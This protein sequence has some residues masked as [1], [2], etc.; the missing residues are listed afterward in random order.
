MPDSM[1][2][3]LGAAGKCGRFF[4]YLLTWNVAR[5]KFDKRPVGSP[6]AVNMTYAQAHAETM[7]LRAIG[8]SATVG[9]WIM[10]DSGLFFL[11]IDALPDEY[12]LDE[13]AQQLLATFPGAFV[14]WST[15]KRGLHIV[16]RMTTPI[17]HSSRNDA[18]HLEFYTA[19]RGIALNIDAAPTGNMDSLHDVRA[20]VAQYFPPR[21][22]PANSGQRRPDWRGPNDDDA[23]IGRMLAARVSAAAAFGGKVSL[24]HLW[25]G[26]CTK[27]SGNDMALASHLAF[28]TGCDAERIERLMRRSGMVRDKWRTHRTYLQTTI[29]AA[30]AACTNVYKEPLPLPLL[31]VLEPNVRSGAALMQRTFAPVQWALRGLI[32]QGTEILSAPPKAG[33]S[34]LVLQ[35][36]I[37][38]AAGVP[39]WPG[40]EPEAQGDTLYL[41]LEG[42]DRRLQERIA[43]LLKSFPAGISLDQFFYETEWPRAEAGAA[44]LREWLAEHPKARLVIIDTLASWRDPDPGRMSAYQNDYRVGEM[45][46][47]LAREFPVAIVIVTHTRKMGASDA[48]DKISGTQGLVGGVDNYMILSRAAGNMD[49]ELVVNGRDIREPQELALRTL[50]DGGWVCVGNIADVKR[51]DERGDVLRALAGLGGVGTSKEI[52]AELENPVTHPTLY[53][54]LQRMAKAGE[55]MKSGKL[56][57]LLEIKDHNLKLPPL[58]GSVKLPL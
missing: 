47:P 40:R 2:P 21:D 43:G 44:K 45:L 30:C 5:G 10:P 52:H 46:K 39:L 53:K 51:T 33:K 20:V 54:R 35:A 55:I 19:E 57:T 24:S 38:V 34:W 28:W 32:P 9:M 36:C 37:A 27:D 13:R 22:V 11:D 25:R 6:A 14:E 48:M 16:G 50:K 1:L 31:A 4:V 41:D 18:L 15:G 7:R 29:N 3:A 23:L 12:K 58:P 17:P 42:N 8:Q 56:F 49:A 26:E